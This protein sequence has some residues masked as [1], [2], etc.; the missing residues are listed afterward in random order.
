M[1]SQCRRSSLRG[2]VV[3]AGLVQRGG[4]GVVVEAVDAGHGDGGDAA[5][6]E[7]DVDVL[8]AGQGAQFLGDGPG[9]VAAGHT[10]DGEGLGVHSGILTA[11]S[12]RVVGAA[13]AAGR[14]GQGQEPGH[15]D[16][17]LVVCFLY[18]P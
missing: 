15:R 13:A 3:V 2:E 11:R 5:R 18:T 12:G 1:S 7:F 6:D 8:D 16:P 10:D 4:D 9:A 17:P 14:V